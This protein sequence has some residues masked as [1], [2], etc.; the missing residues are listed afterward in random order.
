MKTIYYILLSIAFF[1]CSKS[2]VDTDDDINAN[3]STFTFGEG[4]GYA[5]FEDGP[6]IITQFQLSKNK[7][8]EVKYTDVGKVETVLNAIETKAATLLKER[9]IPAYLWQ[10]DKKRMVFGCNA[11]ANLK[12]YYVH[13]EINGD[14][15]YWSFDR[16]IETLPVELREYVKLV[17]ETVDSL[18]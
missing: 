7:L 16:N 17:K 12:A 3:I 1:S 10:Q 5:V 9:T 18:I 15:Y 6:N 4:D 14:K 2:E 13:I 11:C 8:V